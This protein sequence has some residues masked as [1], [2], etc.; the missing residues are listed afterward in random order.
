VGPGISIA[1]QIDLGDAD[2]SLDS[3]ALPAG[4]GGGW[5]FTVRG[6]G[7]PG[8][9]GFVDGPNHATFTPGPGADSVTAGAGR[10]WAY[11]SEGAADEADLYDLGPDQDTID[12]SLAAYPVS[13]SLAGT[14]DNGAAGEGDRILGAE[15]V[16]GGSAA[17]VLTGADAPPVSEFGPVSEFYG[18]GGDDTIVGGPHY[19]LI[20][21]GPGDDVINGLDGN[22][23]LHGDGLFGPDGDDRVRGGDGADRVTGEGGEDRISGGS[24]SDEVTGSTATSRDHDLDRIDCGPG[25]DGEAYVGREDRVRRCEL[26]RLSSARP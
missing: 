15:R 1:F 19:D 11:A 3:T 22:D 20:E 25:F 10:D 21:G 7:G 14:A 17:D 6:A 23:Q 13:V 16:R 24:G 2:D 26:V 4:D 5:S 8:A 18:L 12:Y 9:D